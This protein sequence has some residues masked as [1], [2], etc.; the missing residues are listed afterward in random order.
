MSGAYAYWLACWH[1]CPCLDASCGIVMPPSCELCAESS[2][3]P[4][5]AFG[6]SVLHGRAWGHAGHAAHQSGNVGDSQLLPRCRRLTRGFGC[7]TV[8]QALSIPMQEGSVSRRCARSPD[9][10]ARTVADA[11]PPFLSDVSRNQC[12]LETHKN[13]RP[14]QS[15]TACGCSCL[16]GALRLQDFLLLRTCT[17]GC[18]RRPA[19]PVRPATC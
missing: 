5:R 13:R 6:R 4:A 7:A 15:P 12:G 10:Q 8:L 18:T 3:A 1:A 14:G 16:R 17:Q 11:L 9:P 2:P 19:P